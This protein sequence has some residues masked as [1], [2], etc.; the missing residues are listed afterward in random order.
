MILVVGATAFFGRQTVETLAARGVPVRALTRNPSTAGLPAGV[1]VV[2]AD[3]T[4][5]SSLDPAL[6]GVEALLLVLPYGL[7]PAPLLQR[8]AGRRIVVL[9]SGAI[10]GSDV[11]ASYHA[12]L[13]RA[14]A[15]ATD[16]WTALRILFPAINSLSYAHQLADGPV[17]RV[18]YPAA[19][20][21]AVHELDVAEAAAAI[22]T[23]D[24]GHDGRVY[25]LTGPAALTQADQVAAIGA[26]LGHPVSTE[27]A[28][29][30]AV[31]AQLSA[32]MDAGFAAALLSLLERAERAPAEV[33][34]AVAELTG[35]PARPYAEWVRDHR[36][37]F[38]GPAPAG[39]TT[40]APWIVTPDTAG[41]L[42][43]VTAVFDGVELGRVPLEDG[44]IGH[45]E[46]RVGDTVLLAFDRRPDWPAT[47]SLL[48]V[49]VPDADAAIA[50]AV[51]AGARVVTA[52]ATHAFGQRGGRV[53]D[54]WGNIWW[55]S[56]VVEDVAPEVG[57][58]RLSEPVY[59]QAMHDAQ[60]TLDR[61]LSG[62]TDVV[63]S[64]PVTG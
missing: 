35:H 38:A 20:S 57:M 56:T 19:S 14:V 8:A 21:T 22:L 30:A 39:Y 13:E 46:I 16:R 29:P 37:A 9:S 59:A 51:A 40:V 62:R 27:A 28:D 42:G 60:Q 1:E 49:F 50:R 34:P 18:P 23:P 58:R 55:V 4:D 6:E 17:V 31:L 26:A 7:D 36:S 54:P 44:T 52:S 53:R 10:P 43:F 61:E 5:P 25:T 41:L 64:R 48:R 47:P 24:A 3:L 11:I 2:R 12:G 45:A 32:F 33:T 63:V 15:A